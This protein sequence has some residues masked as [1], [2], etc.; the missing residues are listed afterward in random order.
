VHGTVVPKNFTVTPLHTTSKQNHFTH[1]TLVDSTSL[2]ITS[3]IY[4]Q[5]PLEF[6]CSTHTRPHRYKDSDSQRHAPA[7][8]PWKTQPIL[9]VQVAAWAVGPAWTGRENVTPAGFEPRTVAIPTTQ[10]RR[11]A[12]PHY[13]ESKMFFLIRIFSKTFAAEKRLSYE[14]VDINGNYILCDVATVDRRS[15]KTVLNLTRITITFASQRPV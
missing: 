8:L 1:N 10:P 3:L 12:T 14:G 6:S 5:S 15:I 2:H 11:H 13:T 7:V 4:T 9:I